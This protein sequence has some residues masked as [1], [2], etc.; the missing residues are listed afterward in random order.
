MKEVA[1]SALN[2]ITQIADD[3]SE[4]DL[5]AASVKRFIAEID[6]HKKTMEMA[7]EDRKKNGPELGPADSDAYFS[8]KLVALI[9]F[10]SMA[11]DVGRR[12]DYKLEQIKDNITHFLYRVRDLLA[13]D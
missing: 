5:S 10:A 13:L 11:V 4:S 12:D 8:E 3:C 7:F 1:R 6:F 9:S 2:R